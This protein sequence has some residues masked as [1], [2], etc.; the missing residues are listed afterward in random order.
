MHTLL[1]TETTD[2]E[3]NSASEHLAGT[4]TG[5]TIDSVDDDGSRE[6]GPE[7]DASGEDAVAT[8]TLENVDG[9]D[10]FE[11]DLVRET[12]AVIQMRKAK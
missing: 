12:N 9:E 3:F 10:D 1:I 4:A 8:H 11:G 5:G 7:L 6:A 2:K